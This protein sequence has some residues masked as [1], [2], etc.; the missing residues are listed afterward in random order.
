MYENTSKPTH[1]I[2]NKGSMKALQRFIQLEMK[3]HD[4]YWAWFK[5]RDNQDELATWHKIFQRNPSPR[6]EFCKTKSSLYGCDSVLHDDWLDI[7]WVVILH[8]FCFKPEMV[9]DKNTRK[10]YFH[11]YVSMLISQGYHSRRWKLIIF[12]KCLL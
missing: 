10:E 8:S 4:C 6:L 2:V 12:R 5:G 1:T 11:N 9:S 3:E 7:P